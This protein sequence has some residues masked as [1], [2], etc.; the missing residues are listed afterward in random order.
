[1]TMQATLKATTRDETGKGPARR[2][3]ADGRVPGVIY[4]RD[5]ETVEISVDAS[6]VTHLFQRISVENTIV[7][8]EIDGD[9][10]IPSLVRE[11]QVHPFRPHLLHIDFF[12]IQ[13]GVLVEVE[14]PIHFEG[15]PEGVK[16]Q[17][18]VL[19]QAIHELP[20]RVMP[21]AI[22]DF[23]AIDVS[24]LELGDSLHVSDIE[25]GEGI[26]VQIDLDRTIAS[27]IMPKELVVD[28]EEEEEDEELEIEL[29]ED[30]DGE[31]VP[32]EGE[33]VAETEEGE[34]DEES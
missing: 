29:V 17:G 28:E 30:E 22:P 24:A 11:V 6:E 19:Q 23:F 10:P 15:T 14:V 27:V 12:R 34:A 18:G 9:A 25:I 8:V 13:E 21:R 3:R 5:V 32:A 33:E 7:D 1:M 16:Q 26:E 20:I 31:M 4:G 2:M